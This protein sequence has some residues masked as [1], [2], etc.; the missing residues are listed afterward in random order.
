MVKYL[1]D[2]RG[3]AL[4]MAM[5]ALMILSVLVGGFSLLSSTEPTIAS[6]QLRVAQARA[7]AEAGLEQAVWALS[8]GKTAVDEEHRPTGSIHYPLSAATAGTPYDG[9]QFLSISIGSNAIGGFRVTV[10]QTDATDPHQV[11]VQS[12]GWV[13]T[14]DDADSRTKAH[15]R[16]TATLMDFPNVTGMPC[17]VCVRGDIQIGGTST[18][19]ARPDTTCG[20][21]WG[22]WSTTVKDSSGT[23]I[24][25]GNTTLGSGSPRVY[26]SKD[27]NNTPNQSTDMAKFQSSADFDQRKL[28]NSSLDLLKAYAKSKGTYYRGAVT[29]NSTNKLPDCPPNGCIVFVD[30]VSGQNIPPGTTTSSD[31]ASAAVNGAASVNPAGFKGWLVVNG[32]LSI[33][34]SFTMQG[35][36]YAVN[37]ISYVATGGQIRGQ[38]ISANILDTIATVIDTSASGAA[39]LVYNCAA[40]TD[41]ISGGVTPPGFIVKAGTYKEVSD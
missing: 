34:G 40:T 13:P 18:I 23:T 31:F 20:E 36:I 6:N 26:G 33:S 22:T 4:V 16:I 3:A 11:S 17:A 25:P 32:S 8:A 39:S 28:T 29:F 12:S 41:P 24:S 27:E 30:T 14:D 35:L 1:R 19:D 2:E 38:M 5:L 37:D 21:K 15:Q 7:L 9:S 10:A